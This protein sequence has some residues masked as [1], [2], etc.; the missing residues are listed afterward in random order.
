MKNITF[1]LIIF[2]SIL[3]GKEMRASEPC[4]ACQIVLIAEEDVSCF[5]AND[6]RIKLSTF[7]C[8]GKVSYLWSNGAKTNEIT[9]LSPGKYSVT[10]KDEGGAIIN[11]SYEI[12]E[13]LKL[14]VGGSTLDPLCFGDATGTIYPSVNGGTPMYS[15]LW[16][17]G[18]TVQ[19]I[20][21]LKA[22]TYKLTVTDQNNC[23]ATATY[24]I[25][26]PPMVEVNTEYEYDISCAG[27]DDGAVKV[28]GGG[29]KAPYTYLWSNGSTSNKITKL[30]PGTYTVTVYDIYNCEESKT[31]TL[32]EPSPL[33][34]ELDKKLDVSC[35][36]KGDGSLEV[37][38]KDGTPGYSYDWSNGDNTAKIVNLKPGSY[39]VTVTDKNKCMASKTFT[40]KQPNVL[41]IGQKLQVN[42]MCFGEEKGELDVSI[43]GGTS[44]YSYN[45]SNGKT[46]SYINL[47]A[48]GTYD[49]TVTDENKCTAE[50]SYK[51][52]EPTELVVKLI[53]QVNNDCFGDQLGSLQVEGSGGTAG[54]NYSWSSGDKKASISGLKAGTYDVVV[55]DKN[56]CTAEASY[57]ILE[58][59][60]VES[61]LIQII[62]NSCN[63]DSDGVIEVKGKG[64]VPPYTYDWDSGQAGAR[65][66]K[67]KAGKYTVTIRDK[68]KCETEETYEIKDP[69]ELQVELLLSENILCHGGQT[70]LL[71]VRGLGGTPPYSFAWS[72][73]KTTGQIED[74]KAGK[75]TVI[76]KDKK[77]CE[78]EASYDLTEPDPLNV[79]L[80]FIEHN[81]CGSTNSGSIEI[82]VQGGTGSYS[83]TWS[84]G[85]KSAKISNLSSG[86]FQVEVKDE[87]DCS[88]I[89]EYEIKTTASL[90]PSREDVENIKCHGEKNGSIS[91]EMKGGKA[92]YTYNWS[93]GGT[94]SKI[95]QLGSGRYTVEVQDF[96]GCS[97]SGEYI[98]VEPEMLTLD[99]VELDDVLCGGDTTGRAE[100][101]IKGGTGE[102]EVEWTY[103][104]KG[105][106]NPKLIKVTYNTTKDSLENLGGGVVGVKIT[107]RNQCSLVDS[108]EIV[109]PEKINVDH[110]NIA[111]IPCHGDKSGQIMAGF[112][113]GQ[114]INYIEWTYQPDPNTQPR[115]IKVTYNEAADTLT[116]LDAGMY[117]VAVSDSNGCT[118]RDSFDV[119]QPDKIE[120]EYS[121]V[122]DLRCHN[123]SSGQ[124]QIGLKGGYSPYSVEWTYRKEAGS[125]PRS[126]EWTYKVVNDTLK[127]TQA[128]LI[129]AIISD[130][131]KCIVEKDFVVNQPEAIELS[132]ENIVDASCF[133][134]ND[135]LVELG[136]EGGTNINYVEWTYQPFSG[137]GFKQI[138]VTYN[139]T[140]DKI[141]PA[142]AG[143]YRVIVKDEN[144]CE[145]MTEATVDQPDEIQYTIEQIVPASGGSGAIE[146]EV[147]GGTGAYNYAWTGPKGYTSNQQDIDKL[148][149]G[150]YTCIIEDMN[151]C[152]ISTEV[153]V[154]PLS[155]SSTN[156][157][158]LEASV[159]PQPF[160]DVVQVTF[161]KADQS[162]LGELYTAN[163]QMIEILDLTKA[164]N[165]L[166]LK[167]FEGN[168][169]ILMI[170]CSAG[171]NTV[172]LVR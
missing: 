86:T 138:K 132:S 148:E 36:S 56:G 80:K 166:N 123:D 23:T 154:V 18:Q 131:S 104:P 102:T 113:G 57:K 112:K 37:V 5:G 110:I 4:A 169:F 158:E 78:V 139:E 46:S 42:N 13:P 99:S 109:E 62:E 64:G 133:E 157:P 168:Q 116:Q 108:F 71:G 163:G 34:V 105:E 53:A 121:A 45:W 61:E 89:E 54:Y 136:F 41:S 161:D 33:R 27:A 47:L 115:K 147:T 144:K 31:Y 81:T 43:S 50:V 29:G 94:A 66:D 126:I 98:I 17:N 122:E 160:V 39:T 103:R 72:N 77:N 28:N 128:G 58:N 14:T 100:I 1:L 156:L 150:D 120:F 3:S 134:E 140:Q 68:N 137:G 48:A 142:D 11:K 49:L 9:N 26:N 167:N 65:I 79:E 155:T 143:M 172:K 88:V 91:L 63:G 129:T 74:L 118:Y 162:R 114:G 51:I 107:D 90:L 25:N 60:K 130:G 21:S 20:N 145:F 40:I 152:V 70:G 73:G 6:G 92:P 16:S 67:L 141:D 8:Q 24:K 101:I 170:R 106:L 83:Y 32:T 125:T 165:T 97:F 15:F 85:D 35:H 171:F 87:N 59:D 12:S 111:T 75:Y 10:V 76:I 159:Y 7:G 149:A 30:K 2:L 44:P 127:K 69:A 84:N 96:E 119:A 146:I 52:T 151:G 38:A 22:G 95:S 164:Q 93:N 124:V 153:I 82:S 55:T 19:Y 135:G 117:Y